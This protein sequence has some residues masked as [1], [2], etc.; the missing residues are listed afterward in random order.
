[1]FILATSQPSKT[2][3]KKNSLS[4]NQKKKSVSQKIYVEKN[5]RFHEKINKNSVK[6]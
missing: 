1:M 2:V 4:Q 3:S 5:M 6:W